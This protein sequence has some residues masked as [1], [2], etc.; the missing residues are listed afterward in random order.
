MKADGPAGEL[1]DQAGIMASHRR[2]CEA[3][4]GSPW[5]FAHRPD[6]GARESGSGRTTLGAGPAA[7]D[8]IEWP[9]EFEGKQ[10]ANLRSRELTPAAPGKCRWSFR[11]PYGSLFARMSIPG[12]RRRGSRFTALAGTRQNETTL[13]VQVHV[14]KSSRPAH[15]T[16]T[17]HGIL[18]R[19]AATCGHCPR[20]VLRPDDEG[21]RKF[22]V[23]DE[24]TSALAPFGSGPD[25]RPLRGLQKKLQ[26]RLIVIS[27][28]LKVCAPSRT[29]SSSIA[30]R[31]GGQT[32]PCR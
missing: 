15:G 31:Q 25:H 12:H 20:L 27:H 26:A 29:T 3:V 16:V 6:L 24:P 21:G 19:P 7:A 30:Q 8:F 14:K 18:W 13:I 22:I 32:G 2:S 28:D 23:L 9:I 10:I 17:P 11:D 1:P 4:T 5:R